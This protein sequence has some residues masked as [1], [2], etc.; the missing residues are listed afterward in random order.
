MNPTKEELELEFWR[1]LDNLKNPNTKSV[2]CEKVFEWFWDKI[3]QFTA[4]V[5]GASDGR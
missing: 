2:D 4:G 3:N 1:A 5:R